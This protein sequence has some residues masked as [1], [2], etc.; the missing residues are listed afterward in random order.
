MALA[1]QKAEGHLLKHLGEKVPK[2]WNWCLIFVPRIIPFN[3]IP[4]SQSNV[5]KHTNVTQSKGLNFMKLTS[6]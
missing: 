2:P 4:A 5:L 3:I 6:L 1:E